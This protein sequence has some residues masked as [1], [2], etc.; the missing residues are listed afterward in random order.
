[1][2]AEASSG[3]T[4]APSQTLRRR[5]GLMPAALMEA[6][7]EAADCESTRYRKFAQADIFS[8]TKEEY[9]RQQSNAGSMI[10]IAALGIIGLLVL[11]EFLRYAIGWDAYRTELSVDV[12]TSSAGDGRGSVVPVY[13]DITFP[14]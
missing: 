1:M 5:P 11:Y 10:S 13:F 9:K 7:V 2:V 6:A 14:G 8:K 3:G 4:V 12:T